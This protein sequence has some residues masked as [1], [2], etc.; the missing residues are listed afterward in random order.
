MTALRSLLKHSLSFGGS[1]G[2]FD[3]GPFWS[4]PSLAWT[5]IQPDREAVEHNFAGYIDHAYKTNGVVFACILVRLLCFSEVRFRYQRFERGR[6][7]ELWGDQSLDL[8]ERPWPNGTTGELLARMEQ[9]ASLA[10]NFYATVVGEGPTRRIRR[11]RPDWVTI[12][13]GSPSDDPFDIEAQV[14]GYLYH[15]AAGHGTTKRPDPVLLAAEQVIHYSPIPDPD[16]QWR[17]MSW[18]TPVV[19]EID[20]DTS[21][22]DHKARF[23]ENGA[24]SNVVI[25][26]DDALSEEDFKRAVAQFDLQHKGSRNAYKTIH[27]G[28]GADAKALGAD[29]RQ[30]DFKSTQ[31]A[32]ET[33]IAAASGAGAIIARLSEGMQGSSLNQGN[34]AAAK[35]QFAD[36]T[37]RPLWRM[38]AAS[39][40]PL[41]QVPSDS[42][43][44]YDAR[45]VAFL[46]EDERDAA[47]IRQLE[48]GIIR[49]FIES[50]F[51]PES[52]I[53][54]V[55]NDDLEQLVHTGR[56]SVQLQEPG[57]PITPDANPPEVTP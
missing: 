21:A 48:A 43:L 9:D 49:Q 56:V 54:A 40:A 20:A 31:G 45:D 7:T 41:V 4:R 35:R 47:E 14:V 19:R 36:M 42:R 8:L 44:W 15:P 24:T 1:G 5:P 52:A 33:R 37:I 28:G 23:F 2:T 29:M 51:T 34:Y 32:G 30:L 11:L 12:V 22:T 46:Q 18:V 50:G 16:A 38:A 27:L 57:A 3:Q 53:A 39:L 10:G 13:T 55:R 6:P 25:T 17:G 26:Y